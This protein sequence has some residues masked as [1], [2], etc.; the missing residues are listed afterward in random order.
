MINL[1]FPLGNINKIMNMQI[2]NTLS[3]Q[4]TCRLLTMHH[5]RELKIFHLIRVLYLL[6]CQKGDLIAAFSY[7][8]A[9]AFEVLY[10]LKQLCSI[11]KSTTWETWMSNTCKYPDG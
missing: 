4:V 5:A 11:N 8:D 2:D 1:E 9:V 7:Q 6:L 10:F 3:Y